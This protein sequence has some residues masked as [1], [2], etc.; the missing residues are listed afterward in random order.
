MKWWWVRHG[1]TH[2]KTMAGWT[3]LPADLSDTAAISRLS[4][5]LPH[6]PIISSDLTRAIDTA[7]AIQEKRPRLTHSQHIREINFGAWE[8]RTFKAVEAET[9]ELL[10]SYWEDPGSHAPPD[11]ESWDQVEARVNGFVDH[12]EHDQ[13]DIIAVAHMGTILTQVRRARNVSAYEA[14]AQKIHNL[15]VTCLECRDGLW[16]VHSVNHLP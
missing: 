9:P 5:H 6:A 3:D 7:N 12:F 14:F 13:D 16:T 2:A 4:K 10:R 11:G 15:S 1:P 8:N